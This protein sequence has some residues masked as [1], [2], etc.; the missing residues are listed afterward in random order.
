[1]P[2]PTCRAAQSWDSESMK[3]PGALR[4]RIS[5]DPKGQKR[6]ASLGRSRALTV[7]QPG[8]VISRRP[9]AL[10]D[11]NRSQSALPTSVRQVS[12]FAALKRLPSPL[13]FKVE[14]PALADETPQL[15]EASIKNVSDWNEE[16]EVGADEAKQRAN[17]EAT[18]PS[19]SPKG[20]RTRRVSFAKD[21]KT[22]KPTSLKELLSRADSE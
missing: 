17:D 22:P 5:P 21:T 11:P 4:Q 10:Q 20:E 3:T 6:A 7:P 16:I 12:V 9:E 8:E 1:M 18:T 13:P 15:P 14:N 19:R 2:S